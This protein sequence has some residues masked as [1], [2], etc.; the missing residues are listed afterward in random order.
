MLILSQILNSRIVD[1]LPLVNRINTDT[2][3]AS[4]LQEFV[5]NLPNW[6]GSE[7]WDAEV[8]P[9]RES[10]EDRIFTQ[11]RFVNQALFKNSTLV[12]R[13]DLDRLFESVLALEKSLVGLSAF[14]D[15]LQDD[16]SRS[17]LIR[18]IAH[19]NLGYRKVKLPL[20]TPE[21]W[22][23]R[24][25]A[26]T[27]IKSQDKIKLTFRNFVL[28]HMELSKIGFPVEIFFNSGG[29]VVTFILKQYEYQ[30][31]TPEIKAQAGDCVIDAGGCWGDTALYFA[32]RVG[33]QGKVYTFEFE[34]DNLEVL[35]RN[36]ALNPELS[37]RIE[38]IPKALW[39][40]SGE[41]ILYSLNGPATSLNRD[42]RGS[43]L[44]ST[45]SIDDFVKEKELT[46][47]DFIKMDIEGSELKALHGAEQTLRDF[48]PT[49]A[50]SIYHKDDDFV[51]IP[52]YLE[53]LNLGYEFYLDHFT[54]YRSE[55]ILFASPKTG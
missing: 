27:L 45:L 16:Y 50:I 49:L 21:Y 54:I 41:E 5:K 8:L 19:R 13:T 40:I 33:T 23:M 30:K 48:R 39:N 15:L 36:L 3:L 14:Y 10:F 22:A 6:Y 34:S 55:T 52:S 38:I 44:V 9:Y 20:N 1:R 51:E 11:L 12:K 2:F 18:L 37:K 17:L 35:Q 32:Q 26:S 28:L 31:R 47:V 46:R 42:H 43:L 24:R 7:N 25:F 29:V 4:L 53:N